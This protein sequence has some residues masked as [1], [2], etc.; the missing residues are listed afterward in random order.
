MNAPMLRL[1]ADMLEYHPKPFFPLDE[2]RSTA[3]RLVMSGLLHDVDEKEPGCFVLSPEGEKMIRLLERL[4]V[5]VGPALEGKTGV[6]I[7]HELL[8]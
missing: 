1:L 6:F 7:S 2:E 8:A 3:A 5:Q 4:I